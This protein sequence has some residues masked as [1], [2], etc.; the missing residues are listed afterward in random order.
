VSKG[1]G[2]ILEAASLMHEENVEFLLVGREAVEKGAVEAQRLKNVERIGP[3]PRSRVASYMAAADV[4][5]FPTHSDGFGLTQLE[6]QAC[7]L[8]VIAS[9]HCGSV[10][11]EGRNG[12]LLSE[13]SGQE[14]ARVLRSLLAEPEILRE[15][16][17][18]A[19]R[20]SAD[21]NL[22]IISQQWSELVA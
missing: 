9:R 7:G 20:R 2:E 3:V 16:S 18:H 6:A 15:M 13:I 5:L 21:Y 17:L 22:E 1:I 11:Q 14:I 8:P 12:L 4:F 19:F 10:V